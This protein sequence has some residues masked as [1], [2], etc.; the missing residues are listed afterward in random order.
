MGTEGDKGEEKDEGLHIDGISKD[1]ENDSN[2]KDAQIP[3]SFTT[4]NHFFKTIYSVGYRSD[5][6]DNDNPCASV[7]ILTFSGI[8]KLSDFSIN[9]V[10]GRL[11]EYKI[12]WPV[13]LTVS[14]L[15]HALWIDGKG[16]PKKWTR[17]YGMVKCFDSILAPMR[18]H[19]GRV[20]ASAMILSYMKVETRPE[21]HLLSFPN[22]TAGIIH[23]ILRVPACRTKNLL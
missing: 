16:G 23:V 21:I 6:E 15:L 5:R 12:V 17:F 1:I 22:T 11:L 18:G 9:V 19:D 4:E 3:K 2:Y 8:Y 13:S 20:E 7:A 14:G 10:G